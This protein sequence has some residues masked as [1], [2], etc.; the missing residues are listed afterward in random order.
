VDENVIRSIKKVADE[1]LKRDGDGGYSTSERIAGALVNER[2][3]WLPDSYPDLMQAIIRLGAEWREA[4]V[5][6]AVRNWNG[7]W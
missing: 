6:V 5:E 4:V 7:R 2:L 3:D 1:M